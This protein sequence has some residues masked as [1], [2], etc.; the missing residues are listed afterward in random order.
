VSVNQPLNAAGTV[1]ITAVF[2][3]D[4]ITRPASTS[5]TALLEFGTGRA[6]GFSAT[7][8]LPSLSRRV[9]PVPDTGPVTTADAGSLTP[10]CAPH[11]G[12]LAA[13]NADV[14]CTNVT[15]SLAPGTSTATSSVDHIS[16]AI[17]EL[18]VIIATA[19]KA[20]STTS[21]NATNGATTITNLTIGGQPVDTNVINTTI[22][23]AGSAQLVIN[24]QTVFGTST[25]NGRTVN[26]LHLT[27]LDGTL[28]VV[29]ASATSGAQNCIDSALAR[30]GGSGAR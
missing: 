1:G 22:P 28:D 8:N 18:P 9:A 16:I 10:P 7:I 24:E 19:V 14:L 25:T 13:I 2:A 27:G 20:T 6:F 11:S 30:R 15:T 23:I 4:A 12:A 3:G 26:A 5:A 17:P 29:V 21:C